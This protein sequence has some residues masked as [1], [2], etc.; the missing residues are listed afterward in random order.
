MSTNRLQGKRS[1][2]MATRFAGLPRTWPTSYPQHRPLLA[3]EARNLDAWAEKRGLSSRILMEHAARGVA[4][5]AAALL[6]PGTR[7]IA[8]ICGPGNNGGDGYGAARQLASWGR[9]VRVVRVGKLPASPAA[10][11]E[12][13]LWSGWGEV[14]DA[15]VDL[16]VLGRSLD[17]CALVIDALFGV[18]LDRPLRAPYAAAVRM[19]NATRVPRL[20]VDVPSGMNADTGEPLPVCVRADVTATMVAPKRGFARGSPGARWA[21]RIV[22]IDIGL[23]RDLHAPYL[24]R[25]GN[26]RGRGVSGVSG[27][28]EKGD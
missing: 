23:P 5:V 26:V 2:Y 20:S 25:A 24:L 8:V 4:A 22:E 1:P 10:A 13:R 16:D 15:S 21:G 17:G 28:I 11:L 7:P 18:G 6:P 27:A 19:L 14:A 3:S 9:Q 12:A